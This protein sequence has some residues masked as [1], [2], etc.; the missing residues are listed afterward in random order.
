[1]ANLGSTVHTFSVGDFE[2]FAQGMG[3]IIDLDSVDLLEHRGRSA[4]L[5]HHTYQFAM[6]CLKAMLDCDH[7][8]DAAVSGRRFHQA[9]YKSIMGDGNEVSF[10]YKGPMHDRSRPDITD[11][12]SVSELRSMRDEY[13]MP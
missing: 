8:V 12:T 4:Q 10:K 1:M 13:G 5:R 9:W 6:K 2:H 11:H 3:T 7:P